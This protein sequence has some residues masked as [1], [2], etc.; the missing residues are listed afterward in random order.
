MYE[1]LKE[2]IALFNDAPVQS[3]VTRLRALAG[4]WIDFDEYIDAY[5]WDTDF[6]MDVGVLGQLTPDTKSPLGFSG[7]VFG[8]TQG[9]PPHPEER[10][11][12]RWREGGSGKTEGQQSPDVG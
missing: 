9:L 12:K 6:L 4:I 3:V 7:E 1:C 5:F 2:H 8:V 10:V 11:L